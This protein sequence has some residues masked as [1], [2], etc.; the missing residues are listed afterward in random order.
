MWRKVWV[1]VICVVVFV[2]FYEAAKAGE[3]GLIV[4]HRRGRF[5]EFVRN[6]S[7]V[8]VA[9]VRVGKKNFPTPLGNGYIGEKRSRPIFRF[10]DPG[11]KRGQIVD[12]AECATGKVRVNY[13]K[14]RAL[15][16]HYDSLVLSEKI[17]KR[18]HLD[19]GGEERFSIHSVTCGETIGQAISKGCIG[20]SIPDMLKL[21][22]FVRADHSGIEATRFRVID[23]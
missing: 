5:L 20:I 22:E 21:F 10:V 18:R 4:I 16:L 12:S 3:Y 13:K 6:D 1:Y 15:M 11:P 23:D 14:M 17:I 7:T 2:T 19:V 8:F 9:P